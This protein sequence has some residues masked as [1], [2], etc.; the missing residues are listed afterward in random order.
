M[1]IQIHDDILH[2]IHEDEMEVMKDIKKIM[3]AVY[4]PKNGMALTVSPEISTKS[5]AYRDF[6][7]YA[8]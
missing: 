8:C 7:G 3:E 4:V 2:E 6:E 5:W 1:V